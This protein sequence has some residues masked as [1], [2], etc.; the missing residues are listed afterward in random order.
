[1][2]D[3]GNIAE[4]LLLE[5]NFMGFI[6]YHKSPRYVIGQLNPETLL[7]F[8][9]STKKVGVF[10]NQGVESML[11]IAEKF[12]LDYFQLHGSESPEECK[13]LKD[14]GF[15]VIKAFSVGETFDFKQ[16]EAY[17]TFV[18]FFLFDTMAEGGFGGHGITFNWQTMISYPYATP[19]LLAGGVDLV[20][21]GNLSILKDLPLLGIDVN[22]KFE[23]DK[24]YKDINKLKKL[25]KYLN[26]INNNVF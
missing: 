24:A 1:M 3:A 14:R 6:F 4:V 10:V 11:D 8:P 25:K 9:I 17:L 18:D 23:I 13:E 12:H 16:L 19:F 7:N 26:Q 22:S 20:N 5:P 2:R 15:G 21:L